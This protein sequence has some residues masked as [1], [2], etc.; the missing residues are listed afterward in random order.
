MREHRGGGAEG[1]RKNADGLF[2]RDAARDVDEC[3]INEE[4]FVQRRELGGTQL[5]WL[6]EQMFADQGLV[7]HEGVLERGDDDSAC[8]KFGGQWLVRAKAAVGEDE[9]GG[10][11]DADRRFGNLGRGGDGQRKAVERERA[12]RAKAPRFVGARRE[13]KRGECFVG[14]ALAG[15]PPRGERG[16][17]AGEVRGE[18]FSGETA[19]ERRGNGKRRGGHGGGA[20]RS[21]D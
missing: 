12:D 15:D 16:R 5:G 7:L 8:G 4:G 17:E 14:G 6:G 2:D 3:A 20:R 9:F 21:G 19:D 13:R 11:F 1:V 10:F 18:G